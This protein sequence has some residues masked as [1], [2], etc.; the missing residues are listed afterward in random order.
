MYFLSIHLI[1]LPLFV[2][3]DLHCSQNDV[4]SYDELYW[5]ETSKYVIII[6]II[7]IIIIAYY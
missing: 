3:Q 4:L 5:A 2:L 7:I 1:S 6:I